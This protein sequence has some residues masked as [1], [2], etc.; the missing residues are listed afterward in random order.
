MPVLSN[1]SPR[2]RSE[3]FGA[4]TW[5]CGRHLSFSLFLSHLKLNLSKWKRYGAKS[6]ALKGSTFRL[7]LRG[8]ALQ[9]RAR[10]DRQ[11]DRRAP[12]DG[13]SDKTPCLLNLSPLTRVRGVPRRSG[14][15]SSP[16]ATWQTGS[17][18]LLFPRWSFKSFRV[19]RVRP[20]RSLLRDERLHHH[21]SRF[22]LIASTPLLTSLDRHRVDPVDVFLSVD[23]SRRVSMRMTDVANRE[24]KEAR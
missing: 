11:E 21:E 4:P 9:G 5:A 19:R 16:A 2:K 17:P 15:C 24:K 7:P 23:R 18:R 3:N 1:S 6:V 20:P 12:A 10:V 8:G 22:V 13:P 14:C